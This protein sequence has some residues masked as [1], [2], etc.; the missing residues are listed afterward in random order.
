MATQAISETGAVYSRSGYA[1]VPPS[2]PVS[3][4]GLLP[5]VGFV[6][7]GVT[8]PLSSSAARADLGGFARVGPSRELSAALG[9]YVSG[10]IVSLLNLR[11]LSQALSEYALGTMVRDGA[12]RPVSPTFPL[13]IPP[14]S[15]TPIDAAPP[16]VGNFDPAPGTAIA[17]TGSV[18]FDVTDDSGD[19]RRIFVVAYFPATGVA[20][21]VHDG[22]GFR[23]FYAAKSSRTMIAGG[24]RYTLLR[25]GGW[26]GAPTIQTFAI[27]HAGNEAN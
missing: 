14:P 3:R 20:E 24:F 11:L 13:F 6:G 5:V 25:S 21:V 10:G 23:G 16:V 15:A 8:R 18:T 19:F 4:A 22:D 2:R 7:V 12:A 9:A 17:R 26:P 27:D 1:G